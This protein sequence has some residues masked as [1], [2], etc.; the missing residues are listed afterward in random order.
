MKL[1]DEETA[2]D[3]IGGRTERWPG[4]VRPGVD[5]TNLAEAIR[6]ARYFK[7]LYKLETVPSE[8]LANLERRVFERWQYLSHLE[9]IEHG[10]KP[11]KRFTFEE[12]WTLLPGA[13]TAGVHQSTNLRKLDE[14]L[15][16]R[17]TVTD[18]AGLPFG[19]EIERGIWPSPW[20]L[21]Q[22]HENLRL[23]QYGYMWTIAGPARP[24]ESRIDAL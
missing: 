14:R 13:S 7:K 23:Q 4:E 24:T 16:V 3:D 19:G 2:D 5:Y 17:G 10:E 20:G 12:S 1:I 6:V 18:E 8:T 11:G 9:R 15:K 22:G 21:I